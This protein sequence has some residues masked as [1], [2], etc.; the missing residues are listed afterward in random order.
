[1][2]GGIPIDDKKCRDIG[3]VV[4]YIRYRR[5]RHMVL[6]TFLNV[7]VRVTNTKLLPSWLGSLDM[8]LVWTT[9]T[10]VIGHRLQG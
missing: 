6:Q 7:R 2:V 5:G 10:L 8:A 3:R 4:D 1:M 9:F